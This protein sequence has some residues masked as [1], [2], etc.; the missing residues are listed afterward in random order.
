MEEYNNSGYNNSGHRNSGYNN[1]GNRNSG[2]YNSGYGCSTN[3]ETGIFCNSESTINIFNK[4]SNLKWD[5]IDHPST[6]GL[7]LT[8]WINESDMTDTEKK[9]NENFK[10]TGGYLKTIDYK[11]AWIKFWSK[12][13]KSN[14]D[15][16]LNL[17][18]FDSEI[19]KDIT[20]I[21]IFKDK[22]CDGKIVEID[23]LEYELKLLF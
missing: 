23:G 10:T 1:S 14:K 20:G 15:K 18:N 12:T 16:F 6:V 21:E 22:T 2:N 19:F 5:E 3:R 8:E 9:E 4:D 11:E 7:N 13:P 17:P